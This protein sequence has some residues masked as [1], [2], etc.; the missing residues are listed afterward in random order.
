MRLFNEVRFRALR[1]KELIPRAPAII[2]SSLS[3]MTT[4]KMSK[5]RSD[6]DGQYTSAPPNRCFG[7]LSRL[8][9]TTSIHTENFNVFRTVVCV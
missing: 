7:D 4:N 2:N 9:N 5:V 8:P 1:L 3:G 6:S